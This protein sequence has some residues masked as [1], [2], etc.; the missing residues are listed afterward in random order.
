MQYD[1]PK[2]E[3]QFCDLIRIIAERRKFTY[4]LFFTYV[5]SILPS[6]NISCRCSVV[7]CRFLMKLQMECETCCCCCCYYPWLFLFNQ[8]IILACFIP[9]IAKIQSLRLHYNEYLRPTD[10]RNISI[11]HVPVTSHPIHFVF[12]SSWWIGGLCARS[13]LAWLQS[14]TCLILLGS[15]CRRF[16]QARSPLCC[17]SNSRKTLN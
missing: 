15:F 9:N 14:N 5:I 8:P 16:I 2:Y 10:D 12:G 1:W 3:T 7:L 13:T 4:N 6:P 11:G 17:P